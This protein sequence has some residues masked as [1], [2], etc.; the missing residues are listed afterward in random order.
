MNGEIMEKKLKKIATVRPE[1]KQEWKRMRDSL[2]KKYIDWLSNV[3]IDSDSL[4]VKSRIK[5]GSCKNIGRTTN[6]N[7]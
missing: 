5:N 4:D 7:A 2:N 1:K 6:W 3:L